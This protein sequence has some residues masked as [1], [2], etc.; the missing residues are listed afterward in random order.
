LAAA[1]LPPLAAQ[2]QQHAGQRQWAAQRDRRKQTLG[3]TRLLSL[4][5][6]EQCYS[7]SL[8]FSPEPALAALEQLQA[9]V[10]GDKAATQAAAVLRELLQTEHAYVRDLRKLIGDYVLPLRQSKLLDEEQEAAVFL[11][12]EGL[13]RVHA[14]LLKGAAS[15]L[16]GRTSLGEMVSV[17]TKELVAVLPFFKVYAAFCHRYPSALA[18]LLALRQANPALEQA[19]AQREARPENRHTSLQSLLIKPVQRICKYPLLVRALERAVADM[20]P[21]DDVLVAE[22]RIAA[23]AVDKIAGEVNDKVSEAQSLDRVVEVQARFGPEVLLVEPHRRFV[24]QTEVLVLKAPSTKAQRHTLFLFNDVL[25]LG[26]NKSKRWSGEDMAPAALARAHTADAAAAV[27]QQ[28][29][30]QTYK[31]VERLDLRKCEVKPPSADADSLQLTQVTRVTTN[32]ASGQSGKVTTCVGRFKITCASPQEAARLAADISKES[33]ALLS[34]DLA[35]RVQLQHPAPTTQST[36]QQQQQ[37]QP[38]RGA[39]GRRSSLPPNGAAAQHP[40]ASVGSSASAVHNPGG[41]APQGGPTGGAGPTRGWVGAGSIKRNS[42]KLTLDEVESRYQE[43]R[44]SQQAP[45]S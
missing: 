45:A 3:T 25:V 28:Q 15:G 7:S 34:Q 43:A 17:V 26:D 27:Q 24:S 6:L 1:A 2:Q 5:E 12:A 18:R 29:Q 10:K 21:A 19:L 23:S 30:Q 20:R 39:S 4:E 41:A 38:L 35:K 44:H 11:N 9:E 14:E 42:A 8:A 13:L 32:A 16:A 31:L 33:E 40:V 22:L 36:T 37:Q